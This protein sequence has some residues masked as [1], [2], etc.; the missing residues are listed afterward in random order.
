M[1]QTEALCG[2]LL[3][4]GEF[5]GVKTEVNAGVFAPFFWSHKVNTRV[6]QEISMC[7]IFFSVMLP[8]LVEFK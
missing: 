8:F 5:F 3:E 1:K 4:Y 2:H 7:A 6:F